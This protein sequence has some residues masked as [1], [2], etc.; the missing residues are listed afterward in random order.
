MVSLVEEMDRVSDGRLTASPTVQ[1]WYSFALNRFVY[2][3]V[4]LHLPLH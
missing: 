1:Y 4:A 2:I 3:S